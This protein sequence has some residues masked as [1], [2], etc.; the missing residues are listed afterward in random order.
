MLNVDDMF[1]ALYYID[2]AESDLSVREDTSK[3]VITI[4]RM[5]FTEIAGSVRKYR[6]GRGYSVGS[7]L[8]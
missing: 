4:K 7:R 8:N 3:A 1:A 6:D 2:E 5:G